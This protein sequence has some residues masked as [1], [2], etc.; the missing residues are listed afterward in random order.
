[1]KRSE[2]TPEMIAKMSKEDQAR[3]SEGRPSFEADPHPPP[4]TDKLERE[5]Q[6]SFAN[7]CLLHNYPCVWH[8]TAHRT[9][10]SL[11]CPDFI[12]GVNGVTL[13]IEFKRAPLGLSEDQK[14]FRALM[15]GQGIVYHLVYSAEEAIALTE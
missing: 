14:K 3:Y 9:K 15:D 13:W 10:A 12:V 6:R 2:L 11:G 8:S 4:V 1:M 5:E 7:W